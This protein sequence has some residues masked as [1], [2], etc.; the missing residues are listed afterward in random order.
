MEIAIKFDMPINKM[1]PILLIICIVFLTSCVRNQQNA[2]QNLCKGVNSTGNTCNSSVGFPGKCADCLREQEQNERELTR[3][4]D[5]S[6]LESKA[7]SLI[8]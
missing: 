3:L 5:I 1:K 8:W 7:N 6:S 2:I 4:P